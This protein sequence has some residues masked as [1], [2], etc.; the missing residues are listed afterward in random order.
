MSKTLVRVGGLSAVLAAVLITVQQVWT[1]V[2]TGPVEN[3]PDSVMYSMQLLLMVFAV[4]GIALAQQARAGRFAQIAALVAMLGCVLWFAASETEVTYL[5][6]LMSTG[7]QL[8]D[9]PGPVLIVTYLVSF[10]LFVLGLLLLSVSIVLT[11]V[12]PRWAAV[13]LGGGLILGLALGSVIPGI[14][15]VYAVGLGWLG[16]ACVK[17]I[18]GVGE[19][20]EAVA[21]GVVAPSIPV[22]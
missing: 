7:S 1:V 20:D 13:V 19:G 14:L 2:V 9:D 3:L 21:D 4:L 5:P 12:L 6:N 17:D 15:V 8:V 10:V 16:I 22:D 18:S 11:R